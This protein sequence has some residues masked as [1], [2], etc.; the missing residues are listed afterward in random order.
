MV[1]LHTISGNSIT[2]NN[3][4]GIYITES[5][6]NTIFANDIGNNL[7]GISLSYGTCNNTLSQNNFTQNDCGIYFYSANNNSIVQN[8]FLDN[9][10]QIEG[11][12]FMNI[13][14]NGYPSGGNY[15][16]D[17][18]GTDV[19]NDGIGDTAYVISENNKDAYP[20]MHPYTVLL[21]DINQDRTVD[22]YDA[23]LLANAFNSVPNASN[24]N[25]SA[26]FNN[27]SLIDIYDAIILA[28]NYG[29]TA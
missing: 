10:H 18:N 15:W 9:A 25:S 17:Y 22:I 27:D 21:G 4:T 2:A 13:W 5:S 19:N 20:L 3:G 11:E 8:N 1:L 6:N 14:D 16:S 7:Q 26:D 28:N 24:W 23:I 12:Y 29:K